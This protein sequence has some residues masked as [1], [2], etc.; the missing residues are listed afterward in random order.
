MLI[1][2][3]SFAAFLAV[4][5]LGTRALEVLLLSAIPGNVNIVLYY[6]IGCIIIT[7]ALALPAFLAINRTP[8]SELKSLFR[9]QKKLPPLQL[10]GAA[11]LL[12]A[13]SAAPVLIMRALTPDFVLSPPDIVDGIW[14]VLITPFVE[15]IIFR[16]V[17]LKRL[18]KYGFAAAVLITSALFAI[19]HLDIVNMLVSFLPGV[20]LAFVAYRTDSIAY[21]IPLHM[22]VNLCGS[23]VLPVVLSGA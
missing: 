10:A 23:V 4:N 8:L 19:G 9:I 18:K 1:A 16:G 2:L 12:I 3:L 6:N 5:F 21:T 13:L 15:E 11:A 20:A 17:M 14:L 22:M 7:L